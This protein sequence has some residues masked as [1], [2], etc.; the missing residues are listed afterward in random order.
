MLHSLVMVYLDDV[1]SVF[2]KAK[3][4]DAKVEYEPMDM[5]YGRREFGV[6]DIDGNLWCFAKKLATD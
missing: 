6:R 4:A 3:A 1:D 2:E 5:P